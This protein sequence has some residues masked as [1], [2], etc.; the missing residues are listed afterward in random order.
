MD[1][2]EALAPKSDQLDAVDLVGGPRIFTVTSTGPGNAEQ[3]VQVALAEFPRVWR[4]SKGMLRILAAAWG[5][6]ST[7]W[8]GRR[9]ELYCDPTVEFGGQAV[10]GIR[11]ASLSHI[12]RKGIKVPILLKRGR[13]ATVS[14]GYLDAPAQPALVTDEQVADLVALMDRKGS[15]PDKRV[16]FAAWATKRPVDSLEAL[17]V[18][19]LQVVAEALNARPDVAQE[20]EGETLE[21]QP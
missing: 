15:P 16:A 9:V 21:V 17:T 18:D 14:V 4:P 12:D 5:T 10:G 13:S 20:T 3:P 19:E 1:I 2:T 11:I 6:D 8:S 7:A